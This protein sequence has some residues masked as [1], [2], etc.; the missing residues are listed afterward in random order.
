LLLSYVSLPGEFITRI[1]TERDFFKSEVA[2]QSGINDTL[3]EKLGAAER[4]NEWLRE[5][6]QKKS[7]AAGSEAHAKN[8]LKA[9]LAHARTMIN[10]EHDKLVAAENKIKA[11]ERQV[12]ILED[13]ALAAAA[14]PPPTSSKR[15]R[16]EAGFFALA[17]AREM[18]RRR[19][20]WASSK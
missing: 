14:P 20:S 15:P 19:L 1:C 10:N 16:P 6:V 11:L 3:I 8:M 18:K 13:A 2:R 17:N 9:T 12:D 5:E 7:W 4:E